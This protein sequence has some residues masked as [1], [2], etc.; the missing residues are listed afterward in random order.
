[1]PWRR[2]ERPSASGTCNCSRRY[3]DRIVLVLDGDEGGRTRTDQLLELFI[4]EP[5]DLR[6]LT[7]PDNLDPCDFLLA[8][9]REAFEELLAGAADALEHKFRLATG[10]I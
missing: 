4:A 6:V 2:W 3:A 9:G 10:A 1:M 5:I 7:L 8:R